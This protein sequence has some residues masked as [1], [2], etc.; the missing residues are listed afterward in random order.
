MLSRETQGGVLRTRCPSFVAL[1][2]YT[3]YG[4]CQVYLLVG[5]CPRQCMSD[6]IREEMR[7]WGAA[8]FVVAPPV[9]NL[10][11]QA[12]CGLERSVVHCMCCCEGGGGFCWP[13]LLPP[14]TQS[15]WDC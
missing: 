9:L 10:C 4:S 13:D 1:R 2:G 12:P 15:V 14:A 11:K 5:T 8:L 7:V 3:Y 6:S